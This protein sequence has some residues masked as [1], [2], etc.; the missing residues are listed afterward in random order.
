MFKI[1]HTR[2][3]VAGLAAVVAVVGGVVMLA[4]ASLGTPALVVGNAVLMVVVAA[5]PLVPAAGG[6]PR[7][8]LE[9]EDGHLLVRLGMRDA[10]FALRRSI[11]IPLTGISQVTTPA[12]K[13]VPRRGV[14]LPGTEIPGLIRAGSYGHKPSREFWDVRRG[15]TVLVIDTTS[16]DPYARLVLEVDDPTGT[17]AWLRAVLSVATPDRADGCRRLATARAEVRAPEAG[18][19]SVRSP[20]VRSRA[21]E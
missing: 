6:R 4:A 8:A 3:T 1:A 21:P 2:R 20:S 11:S 10:A 9:V 16:C 15:Q 14:R 18:S 17:A 5:A 19:A 7:I 13:S 12:T